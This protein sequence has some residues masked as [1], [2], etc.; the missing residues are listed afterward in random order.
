M[1]QLPKNSQ[2]VRFATVGGLNT[3]IDFGI[4][5]TMRAVG[6][7]EVAANL[8]S[9][10]VSFVFSFVAN[11]K[12]TFRTRDTDVKREMMLFVVVTLFGLWVL[13]SIIIA[14]VSPALIPLGLNDAT[15]LLIAKVIATIVSLVWNYVLYSRLVFAKKGAE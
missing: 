9:T 13:Q 14:L 11:K 5:F 7:P 6:L 12:Y 10:T 3:A 15:R 2:V 4:L 1:K 8:V